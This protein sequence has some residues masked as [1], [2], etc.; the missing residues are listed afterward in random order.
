MILERMRETW[1]I[2]KLQGNMHIDAITDLMRSS[3]EIEK[4]GEGG[5]RSFHVDMTLI[6]VQ[7]LYIL[8]VYRG[9]EMVAY[10]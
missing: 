10:I 9:D 2:C 5:A 6:L 8:H 4:A 1:M 3:C 7:Y